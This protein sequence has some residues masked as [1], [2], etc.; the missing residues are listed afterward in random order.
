MLRPDVPPFQILPR[1]PLATIDGIVSARLALRRII[2]AL[3][4]GYQRAVRGH[5]PSAVFER[6]GF[7]TFRREKQPSS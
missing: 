7:A 4:P 3:Q 5:E 2:C 6:L 1:V